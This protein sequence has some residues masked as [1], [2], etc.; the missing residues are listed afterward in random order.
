M[1]LFRSG[2]VLKSALFPELM[3]KAEAVFSAGQPK[4]LRS[5]KKLDELT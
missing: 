5:Q 2:E 3:L 4:Y 1:I